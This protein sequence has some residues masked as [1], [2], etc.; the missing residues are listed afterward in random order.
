MDLKSE[1]PTRL[2]QR[3]V[4]PREVGYRYQAHRK[5]NARCYDDEAANPEVQRDEVLPVHQI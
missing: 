1:V 3:I 2:S 5:R 4:Q